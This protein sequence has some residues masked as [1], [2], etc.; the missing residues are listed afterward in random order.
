ML[1]NEKDFAALVQ[2]AKSMPA[3]GIVEG[4]SIIL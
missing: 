1:Y 2:G 4:K 3:N